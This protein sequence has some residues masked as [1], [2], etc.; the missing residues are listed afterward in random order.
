MSQKRLIQEA[1]DALID[2]GIRGQPMRDVNNRP[3]KSI[4]EV[5]EGKEG[6]FRENS[7]GKR[8]DHSGRF[9][10]VV[11]PSPSLHQC[12]LPRESSIELFQAFVIRNLIGRHLARNLRAARNMV[13][14]K[15][16]IIWKQGLLLEYTFVTVKVIVA[17]KLTPA[18][19]MVVTLITISR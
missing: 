8:V 1:V 18:S 17:V 3:Y 16:P 2:N 5:I 10:I 11:G 12:G 9:V 6:R 13:Q 7:L 4:S 14:K 15:E 19:F